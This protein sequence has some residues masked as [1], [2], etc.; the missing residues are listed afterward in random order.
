[1]DFFWWWETD[2]D[3]V[4]L[5]GLFLN[6]LSIGVLAVLSLHVAI[7]VVFISFL[8][9]CVCFFFLVLCFQATSDNSFFLGFA[10][11]DWLPVF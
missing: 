7:I 10:L 9:L 4:T 1:M 5:V 3:G 11:L 8:L 2:L 6:F